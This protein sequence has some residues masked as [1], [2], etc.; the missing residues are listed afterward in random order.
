MIASV[1]QERDVKIEG[2][3]KQVG[4]PR[5]DTSHGDR[6]VYAWPG[7]LNLANL[8]FGKYESARTVGKSVG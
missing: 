7:D 2:W 8:S 4:R 3:K 5:I 6:S 1:S